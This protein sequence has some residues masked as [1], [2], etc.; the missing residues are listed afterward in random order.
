MKIGKL[1]VVVVLAAWALSRLWLMFAL[2]RYTEEQPPS[3][4]P[5]QAAA[6]PAPQLS[7]AAV[8]ARG[9]LEH[10][11]Y[12]QRTCARLRQMYEPIL[13]AG[14]CD[15]G[16]AANL[17]ESVPAAARP[18]LAIALAARCREFPSVRDLADAI[19]ECRD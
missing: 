17:P 8:K 6:P 18:A 7:A 12:R 19:D 16:V 15:A 4:A 2:S 10:L 11:E 5:A 13:A 1:A 3:Y 14:S 9:A